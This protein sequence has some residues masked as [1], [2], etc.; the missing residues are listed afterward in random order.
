MF[1]FSQAL[2]RG[3]VPVVTSLC[4]SNFVY[5]YSYNSMKAFFLGTEVQPTAATDLTFAFLSGE[6]LFF[7][8]TGTHMF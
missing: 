2:Y 1:G 6:I 7:L 3:L 4:C 5:F 8:I